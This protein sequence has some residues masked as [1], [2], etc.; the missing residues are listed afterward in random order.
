MDLRSRTRARS[1]STSATASSWCGAPTGATTRSARRTSST[2]ASGPVVTGDRRR[3]A[4]LHAVGAR[5]VRAVHEHREG[6][7]V[8]AGG[9]A[10]AGQGADADERAGLGPG[11][12]PARRCRACA[13]GSSRCARPPR[14]T[15]S[16]APATSWPCIA[17]SRCT[18]WRGVVRSARESPEP[19]TTCGV[20]P[21]AAS[22]VAHHARARGGRAGAAERGAEVLEQRLGQE[23]VRGDVGQADEVAHR[24]RG[25]GGQRLRRG[26]RAC[27]AP[28]RALDADAVGPQDLRELARGL[29]GRP[30]SLEKPRLSVSAP[31]TPPMSRS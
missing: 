28:L 7:R 14:A 31:S 24:R 23:V 21:K 4:V 16:N 25:D 2:P 15:P 18:T 27:P 10:Q 6:D 3:H 19:S 17:S 20:T 9:L 29:R 12:G 1:A 22:W 11:S 5:D 30:P 26:R 13:C 8:P